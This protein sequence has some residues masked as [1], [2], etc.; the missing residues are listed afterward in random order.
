[1][2]LQRRPEVADIGP[3][4]SALGRLWESGLRA[5]APNSR[6]AGLHFPSWR[7]GALPTVAAMTSGLPL[8]L[9]LLRA[10]VLA[11]G[12]LGAG[13]AAAQTTAPSGTPAA[14]DPF[15]AVSEQ[16][17][18]LATDSAGRAGLATARVE[19]EVGQLDPRL[20]LAPCQR[21]EPYLPPGVP[22]WGRT[23]VGLRC[24]QGEKRWNVSLPVTV[25]V[26]A[27]TPVAR[28]ALP[29]GT[30]LGA[31]HL[32]LAE[33]DWATGSGVPVADAERLAGRV[34]ARPLAAGSPVRP[35]DLKAR[36]WFAAGET[37]R[38]VAGGPGWQV[39]SEAEALSPGIEGQTVRL[40]AA[41][42]RLLQGRAVADRQVE[43]ML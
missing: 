41:S 37:V 13:L 16:V 31:E 5:K 29:A 32:E 39:V 25:H 21:I 8:C 42:G 43:V 12:L 2:S 40:R 22:A 15:A 11:G 27:R 30:T 7:A 1:M 9:P 35:N 38:V 28:A 10:T 4:G 24:V 3:M 33:V 26:W 34:L 23:R 6:V 20:R 14:A 36:Q 19:V 18:Q 17:R